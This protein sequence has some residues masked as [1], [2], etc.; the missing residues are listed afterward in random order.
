M[1]ARKIRSIIPSGMITVLAVGMLAVLPACAGSGLIKTTHSDTPYKGAAQPAAATTAKSQP[2][3][4][5]A[6][7]AE[8]QVAVMA[9][10]P[11]V[12]AVR[13]G[14]YIHR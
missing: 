13:R 14:V 4:D 3:A 12:P 7:P 11:A 9:S 2:K 6:K 5:Q 8:V 1:N 10:A